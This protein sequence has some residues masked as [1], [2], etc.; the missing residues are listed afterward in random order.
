M[1]L[2]SISAQASVDLADYYSSERKEM[3]D[4]G[5]CSYLTAWVCNLTV[6]PV[7]SIYHVGKGVYRTGE[8]A[9]RVSEMTMSMICSVGTC[10]LSPRL[11]SDMVTDLRK[12]KSSIGRCVAIVPQLLCHVTGVALSL[13]HP[14]LGFGLQEFAARSDACSDKA[15][16]A[17]IKRIKR[18]NEEALANLVDSDQV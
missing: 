18:E 9:V 11:R 3:K 2:N 10:C 4:G 15:D 16:A 8:L 7:V 14:P 1:S 5:C 17:L 12:T 13:L 6:G